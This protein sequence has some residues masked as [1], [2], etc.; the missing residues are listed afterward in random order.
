MITVMF[1]DGH[2]KGIPYDRVVDDLVL[3]PTNSIWD[4]WKQGIF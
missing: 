1:A 2:A 3:N 4:P